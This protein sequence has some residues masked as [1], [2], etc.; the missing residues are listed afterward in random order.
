MKVWKLI[1]GILS[2]VL[3]M[4]VIFQSCIVGISNALEENN[5][6]GGSGGVI[7]GLFMLSAGIVSIATHK[8]D[9]IGGDIG[10]AV[11]FFIAA[12]FG[13]ALAGGYSDLYV[14][15]GWCV[16]C[17]VLSIINIIRKSIKNNK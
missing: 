7:L 15:A 8:K 3:F 17:A 1:S 6:V 4:F 10:A 5:E 11:L 13:A 14:W 16:I 2:I 12:F 9:G